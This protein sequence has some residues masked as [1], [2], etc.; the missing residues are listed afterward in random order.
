MHCWGT[1]ALF[2]VSVY[3]V[4]TVQAAPDTGHHSLRTVYLA[5]VSPGSAQPASSWNVK[6]SAE[7][8]MVTSQCQPAVS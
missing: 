6:C 4:C 5:V 2:S 1:L 8:E 7:A 3:A